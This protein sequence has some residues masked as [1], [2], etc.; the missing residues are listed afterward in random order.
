MVKIVSHEEYD[1][2]YYEKIAK[3][4]YKAMYPEGDWEQLSEKEQDSF[5]RSA[6]RDG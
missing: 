3:R 2:H 1:R 4:M 5:R 6:R